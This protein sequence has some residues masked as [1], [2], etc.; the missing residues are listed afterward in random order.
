MGDI[1]KDKLTTLKRKVKEVNGVKVNH[2]HSA[3]NI[4]YALMTLIVVAIPVAILFLPL[5]K[6]ETGITVMGL[7]FAKYIFTGFK[8]EGPLQEFADYG[9]SIGGNFNTVCNYL[10]MGQACLWALLLVFGIVAFIFFVINLTKGYLRHSKGPKVFTGLIFGFSLLYALSFTVYYILEMIDKGGSQLFVWNSYMVPAAAL[11]L[12]IVIGC[13]YSANFRECVLECDLEYHEDSEG[14]AVT[15]VTEVHQVT[16]YKYEQA[17]TLPPNLTSIGGHAFSQNQALII[18]TIPLGIHSLGVGA[19]SNCL[20]LR[21]VT[22]PASVKEIGA[23]CFFNCPKLERV[24]Y[25][26]TKDQWR[27]IVRGSNWLTKANTTKVVCS[28][29]VLVV[30]PYN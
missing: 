19:F 20:K 18:A 15:H 6:T 23:N 16:K 29:G 14:N 24:N 4:W 7:D 25:A 2:P 1:M 5:I 13:I 12:L 27:Q 17:S 28:D 21:V 10:I 30:N 3:A 8:L 26:G 9:A 22:I 11:I